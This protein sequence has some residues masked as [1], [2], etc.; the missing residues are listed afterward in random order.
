MPAVCQH[1][2]HGCPQCPSQAALLN[3][4]AGHTTTAAHPRRCRPQLPARPAVTRSAFGVPMS[5][6]PVVARLRRIR[7]T[8][9]KA[10]TPTFPTGEPRLCP[11]RQCAHPGRRTLGAALQRPCERT[12]RT[13]PGSRNARRRAAVT[14]S[15]KGDPGGLELCVL[16]E[17]LHAVVTPTEAGLLVA[18]ERSGD[19]PLG[20]AVDRHGAR[21]YAS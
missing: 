19:V 1:G 12:G 11:G 5:G 4:T 17:R 9:G 15:V 16:L 18:A 7:E 2:L 8:V 21:P 3:G 20:E 6:Y 13:R 14:G 10:A